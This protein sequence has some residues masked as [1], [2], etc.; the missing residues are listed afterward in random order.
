MRIESD[1]GPYLA[2]NAKKNLKSGLPLVVISYL[3]MWIVAFD[4]FPIHVDIGKLTG[5]SCFI[6]GL[7]FTYGLYKFI[8]PYNY[9]MSGL[10]GE[11]KV[12]SNISHK[13]GNEHS[14]LNDVKLRDGITGNIDHVIVGPRGIFAIETKN[15]HGNFTV[16]GDNW[17]LKQSPSVQAK[18]NAKRLYRLIKNANLLDREIP[19]VHAVVVLTNSKL[20]ITLVRMPNM[21]DIV[22]IKDQTDESLHKCVM[23][24]EEIAFKTDE[25][26]K[27]VEFLK[28]VMKNA[29]PLNIVD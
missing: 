26:G 3:F 25:I 22:Q 21:C 4:W 11:R 6:S 23:S 29:T 2:N 7:V 19:L 10:K 17:G 24:Y 12:V 28:Y 27:I 8:Q 20:K 16:D 15:I 1:I 18:N 13:L 14:L 5:P 9:W